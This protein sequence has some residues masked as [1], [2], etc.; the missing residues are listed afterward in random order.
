MIHPISIK[1]ALSTINTDVAHS[2]GF[3]L[4]DQ[5]NTYW[6]PYAPS[7]ILDLGKGTKFNNEQMP[8][9]SV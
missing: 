9:E 3:I 8:S 4:D 5:E 1:K 6:G 7:L 2:A